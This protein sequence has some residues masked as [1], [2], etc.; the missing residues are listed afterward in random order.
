[1]YDLDKAAA[2]VLDTILTIVVYLKYQIGDQN[3]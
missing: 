1:M 2:I 3:S